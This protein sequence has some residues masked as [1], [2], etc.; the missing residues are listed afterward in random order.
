MS[1][2]S[3]SED[4]PVQVSR[5]WTFELYKDC[6]WNPYPEDSLGN[7]SYLV[8]DFKEPKDKEHL[9]CCYGYV[10][11]NVKKRNTTLIN[12][13]GT[14]WNWTMRTGSH[15]SEE[16]RFKKTAIRIGTF[17][18]ETKK[19]M[20]YSLIQMREMKKDEFINFISFIKKRRR[21]EDEQRTNEHLVA[22]EH[23]LSL[24][25]FNEHKVV[26][27][28]SKKEESPNTN[29]SSSND[30]PLPPI[31]TIKKNTKSDDKDVPNSKIRAQREKRKRKNKMKK[32]TKSEEDIDTDTES[33]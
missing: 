26:E 6:A 17:E 33:S 2:H 9:F 15:K 7:R 16:K 23:G 8:Y 10:I 1:Q 12:T 5:Y 32:N 21:E 25:L 18:P 14:Q 29:S 24:D 28:V 30:V 31:L 20:K 3:S 22:N 19:P 13:Y 11:F 4:T 27:Q